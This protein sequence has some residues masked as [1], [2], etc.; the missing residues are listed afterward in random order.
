MTA[1]AAPTMTAPVVRAMEKL[2]L[3]QFLGYASGDAANNLAFSM[4]TSFLLLYYTDVAG[5]SLA[6]VQAI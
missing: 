4:T 1:P 6:L 3:P 2:R 5:L